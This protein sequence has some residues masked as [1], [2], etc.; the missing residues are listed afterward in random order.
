MS[1]G[2]SQQSG[3]VVVT[4]TPVVVVGEPTV[5]VGSAPAGTCDCTI[6]WTDKTPAHQCCCQV[7]HIKVGAPLLHTLQLGATIIGIVMC[8][9]G[10]GFVGS[11]GGGYYLF[12]IYFLGTIA[13]ICM[14]LALWMPSGDKMMLMK[15][16][17]WLMVRSTRPL[18][19]PCSW[20]SSS[21]SPSAPSSASSSAY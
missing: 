17:T 1:D 14:L 20:A 11:A 7:M 10:G 12:F 5:V 15:V 18:G 13:G 6:P 2:Q 9:F 19:D 21:P 16:A 8:C 4:A 3:T